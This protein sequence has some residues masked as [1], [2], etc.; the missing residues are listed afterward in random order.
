M[1]SRK[2]SSGIWCEGCRKAERSSCT[3]TTALMGWW[4]IPWGP[5]YTIGALIRNY[6][7]DESF[8]DINAD[9]L[10]D[11][12]DELILRGDADEA[13]RALEASLQLRDS[14]AARQLLLQIHGE[15]LTEKTSREVDEG[16]GQK[17]LAL[18]APMPDARLSPGEFV[19]PSS[20]AVHL[21]AAPDE[22]A[23]VV[24][25]MGGLG[26]ILSRP[27]GGWVEIRAE[28]GAIGWAPAH[29]LDEPNTSPIAQ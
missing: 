21:R 20:E 29:A 5:M 13:E 6:Q 18:D 17:E 15:R 22:S 14:A 1:T 19:S 7:A 24:G 10:I 26:T 25:P 28:Q 12:A 8:A 16:A 4:G 23:A 11:T 9:L 3:L 2:V 27:R